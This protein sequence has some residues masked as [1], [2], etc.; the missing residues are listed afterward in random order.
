MVWR[1]GTSANRFEP[2]DFSIGKTGEASN[3]ILLSV[4]TSSCETTIHDVLDVTVILSTLTDECVCVSS[5]G[6][7]K[8]IVAHLHLPEL[9]HSDVVE[10]HGLQE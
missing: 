9:A 6:P 2:Q 7:R 3:Q 10:R 4:S 1:L 8:G 5:H